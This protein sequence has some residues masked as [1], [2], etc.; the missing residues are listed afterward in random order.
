MD[1]EIKSLLK[2]LNKYIEMWTW[3][4]ADREIIGEL[5]KSINKELGQ[6]KIMQRELMV[7]ISTVEVLDES[8][9]SLEASKLLEKYEEK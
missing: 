2:E 4:D 6:N 3:S 5:N 9:L 1:D 7:F 8:Q